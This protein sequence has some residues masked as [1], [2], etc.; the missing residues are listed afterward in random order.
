MCERQL[1][2]GFGECWQRLL[3]RPGVRDDFGE[4]PSHGGAVSGAHEAAEVN[5]SVMQMEAFGCCSLHWLSVVASGGGMA[6][7]ADDDDD[8]SGQQRRRRR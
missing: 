4:V 8:G 5:P 7:A 1:E 6:V 2:V 3:E